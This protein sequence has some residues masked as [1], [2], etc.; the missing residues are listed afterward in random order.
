MKEKTR[1]RRATEHLP[2]ATRAQDSNRATPQDLN[3]R[4]ENK[5][6]RE[7][8]TKMIHGTA[9]SPRARVAFSTLDLVHSVQQW[10]G[11]LF[12]SA[13]SKDEKVAAPNPNKKVPFTR[14]P[15]AT[16]RD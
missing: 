9:L 1:S 6:K 4:Q 2:T 10:L 5:P 11:R 8:L 12:L 7:R 16:V 14:H 15:E 13:R 3:A